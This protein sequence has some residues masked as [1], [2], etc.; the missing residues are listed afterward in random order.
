MTR[1]EDRLYVIAE[2][3]QGF[4]TAAQAVACGIRCVAENGGIV[5]R[6]AA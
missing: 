2:R 6:F 1:K 5:V 4:F 3:Q